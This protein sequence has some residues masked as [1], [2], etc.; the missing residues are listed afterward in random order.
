MAIRLLWRYCRQWCRHVAE[1]GSL[2]VWHLLVHRIVRLISLRYSCARSW[3]LHFT[4]ELATATR[5]AK[6][7]STSFSQTRYV[8]CDMLH[9]Y[10]LLWATISSLFPPLSESIPYRLPNSVPNPRRRFS[11][12]S[13]PKRGFYL[14]L[15]SISRNNSL[16]IRMMVPCTGVHCMDR[17][18]PG[19]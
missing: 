13:K 10:P 11:R 5:P 8:I 6:S 1:Y 2:S 7:S 9:V 3:G 19:Q 16:I 17:Q 15:L 12:T 18:Q 4:D 14:F